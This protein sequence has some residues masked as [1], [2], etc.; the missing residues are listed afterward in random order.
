MRRG[1]FSH[2]LRKRGISNVTILVP[3]FDL[4]FLLRLPQLLQELQIGGTSRAS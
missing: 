3:L 4:K 1:I 2:E